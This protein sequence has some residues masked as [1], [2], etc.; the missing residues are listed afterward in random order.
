METAGLAGVA[1]AR[2]THIRGDVVTTNKNTRRSRARAGGPPAG[3]LSATTRLELVGQLRRM[4]DEV[5]HLQSEL[6]AVRALITVTPVDRAPARPGA[7]WT[8]NPEPQPWLDAR[9]A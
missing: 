3:E 7:G 8:P 5:A 4:A 9:S 2:T 6:E 1:P